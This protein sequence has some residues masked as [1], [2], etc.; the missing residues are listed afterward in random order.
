MNFIHNYTTT[1]R[2]EI[3]ISKEQLVLC[4]LS[5]VYVDKI[6]WLGKTV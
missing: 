5:K 6:R 1:L 3:V 4:G 2:S